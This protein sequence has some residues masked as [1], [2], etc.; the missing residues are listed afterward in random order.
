MSEVEKNEQEESLVDSL[1][2][3]LNV[4]KIKYSFIDNDIVDIPGF[5]KAYINDMGDLSSILRKNRKENK[6][7]FN[8][9]CD[10]ESLL[11]DGVDKI[12]YQFGDNWYWFDLNKGFD[13]KILKY[14]GE[15][16]CNMEKVP[17]VNLGIHSYYELLEGSFSFDEWFKKAKIMGYDAIGICDHNTMAGTYP[18]Q[19]AAKSAGMKFIMGYTCDCFD[20]DVV[21]PVKIYCK[22]NTG[23]SRLLRLQ[24]YINVD[25][26][27]NPRVKIEDLL[28]Y[29]EG[30]NV[31]FG[32]CSADWLIDHEEFVRKVAEKTGKVYYQVDPNEYKANRIDKQFLLS[33]A[34]FFNKVWDNSI[35]EPVLISD[36]Y[37]LDKDDAR[38]KIILNKIA[39]GAAHYQ[40]DE[41][42]F[43]DIEEL[44]DSFSKIFSDQWDVKGL[45]E[46]CCAATVEIAEG[47]EAA[48]ETTR[49]FMPQY[50]LTPEEKEKYGDRRNMFNML[51][52]EGFK[53]L[54]PKGQEEKYRKRL[55]YEKY[56]IESTDNIDY[57]LVQYDSVQYANSQG[58]MTG[59]ARGSG[60]SSLILYL[61]GITKLDPLKYDLLF[62]RFLVPDRSGL[63]ESQTTLLQK[64]VESTCYVEITMNGKVYKF[65]RDAQLWID[66]KGE[67]I[68]VYA[69]E[70]QAGDEIIF[71]NRDILWNL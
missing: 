5:G 6:L 20:G 46:D 30:N 25:H 24:K 69:D 55:E 39:F 26:V 35:L 19:K 70:V 29:V 12:L 65:D 63:Y 18:L 58:I 48:Y 59:I 47:V 56:I 38:N 27:D 10:K 17:F 21:F 16:V 57:F 28:D 68:Q 14:V 7:V 62:E 37:Y 2:K 54:V 23:L 1:R 53:R 44:Y 42:Y 45:F 41:Q 50:D 40:S 11:N 61:M 15:R 60:G 34:T 64:D 51:I 31:V 33:M 9:M 67:Q 43:K 71:D 22:T 32:T 8:L 3:W 66:R 36:T 52:E 4:N 49:N 13:L